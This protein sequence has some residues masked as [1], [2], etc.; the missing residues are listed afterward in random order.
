MAGLYS[1][2]KREEVV[3]LTFK[4]DLLTLFCF[5]FCCSYTRV[6]RQ[7]CSLA[8]IIM[9]SYLSGEI[10]CTLLLAPA[11]V[12]SV[13]SSQQETIPSPLKVTNN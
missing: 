10:I 6:A 4:R 13:L 12:S 9:V 5:F 3:T 11:D 2:G 7:P 1:F 8:L